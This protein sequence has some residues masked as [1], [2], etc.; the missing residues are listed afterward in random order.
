MALAGAP[1]SAVAATSVVALSGNAALG[2]GQGIAFRSVGNASLNN[3]GQVMFTGMLTG[4]GVVPAND[5]SIWRDATLVVREGTAASAAGAGVDF[6][7]LSTSRFNE[8]G[9]VAFFSPLTGT[10]VSV[11]NDGSI[12]RDGVLIAREGNAAPGLSG[13]TFAFLS[14]G[15]NLSDAGHVAFSAALAGSG[16]TTANDGSLWSNG[17]LVAR[18]GDFATAAGAGV[19]FTGSF[20]TPT[21]NDVGQ[22]AFT[23][24]LAGT[25]VTSANDRSLWRNGVLVAREGDAAPVVG[26]D[27]AFGILGTPVLNNAGQVAFFSQLTGAAVTAGN[28]ASI[29][30]DGALI[31]REGDAATAAGPGVAFGDLASPHLNDTGQVAFVSGLTGT[32]VTSANDSAVWRDGVII[33]REGDAAP[34]AAAGAEITGLGLVDLNNT[35]QVLYSGVLTGAG[36]AN[37]NNN[38]VWIGDGVENLQVAREG[39][40]VGSSTFAAIFVG[41]SSLNDLGQVSYEAILAN[42]NTGVFLFTPEIH[43]RSAFSSSWDNNSN[44]TLSLGPAHVHDVFIDPSSSHT[45]TGPTG[46]ETVKSLTV[47]GGAGIVTLRLNGGM[48][49]ATNGVTVASTGVLTGD[50]T[51]TSAVT[52]QGTVRAQN[53]S[54][55][56]GLANNGIVEGSGRINAALANQ[57]NGQVR[58]ATAEHLIVSGSAHSNAGRIEVIGGSA[59]FNGAVTNQAGTGTITGRNATLRFNDGLANQGSVALSFGI[60]DVFGDINNTGSVINSG[61][62]QVT[63]YDDVIN[64][65]EIR[66]STGGAS[67]FF[68]AVSGAGSFTG[69]GSVF[70]EGDLR[71]GNSPAL[72][73]FG[74]DVALGSA[75]SSLF[76]LGGLTRGSEYDGIDVAGALTLD[77]TLDIALLNAFDP[78]AGAS[79]DLFTAETIDGMFLQTLFPNLSG[80]SW[81]LALLQDFA[82]TTD[83][84]RLSVASAVPVPAAAWLFGSGLVG[85]VGI[86][87]KKT[88]NR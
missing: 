47:G 11:A 30:R 2:A 6:G 25:G 24:F 77:G 87:R 3:A 33:A 84:L 85:L 72:V 1:N 23:A 4:A 32:G 59:E 27:T 70:F 69:T 43:Y 52:N 63:F 17:V 74:G 50:G 9:Q 56:G 66:T 31:A 36:V 71:P 55:Q 54:I 20:G 42:G 34:T 12:W 57:T 13:I 22:T 7:D 82:G 18:E 64:N 86:A 60:S 40:S 88:G 83:V 41:G 49:T 37:E 78:Q 48:L 75:S 53:V 80:R 58:V 51:I 5:E 67:V 68:G 45:V 21:V 65:G 28:N 39:D 73:V 29:W 16:V 35:G 38:V 44:W 10:G 76:E 8:A 15:L 19:S 26:G 62:G 61:S 79:F 46:A 81:S 14:S